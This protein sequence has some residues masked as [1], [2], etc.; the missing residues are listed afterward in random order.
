VFSRWADG[1]LD[2]YLDAGLERDPAGGL[3]LTYPREWEA[4][5]FATT[6]HDV[7]ASVRRL[8][9][10]ALVLRGSRSDTFTE[11][12][13]ARFSRECPGA[14]VET[15]PGTSHFLPMERPDEVA[16]RIVAFVDG[17]PPEDV[18]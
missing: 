5:I 3:R 15:V 10:P 17:L 8:A 6:P 9:V 12:A 2:D 16:D 18:R 1:V 4:R 13:A 11:A 14:R 7:W